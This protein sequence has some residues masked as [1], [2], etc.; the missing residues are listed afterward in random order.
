MKGGRLYMLLLGGFLAFVFLSELKAPRKFTWQPTYDSRDKEPFGCYVFDDVARSSFADYKVIKSTFYQLAADV[1]K[2]ADRKAYL[3]VEQ[4]MDVSETDRKSIFKL[5]DAGTDVMLCTDEPLKALF[6]TLQF[7]CS[8]VERRGLFQPIEAYMEAHSEERDSIYLGSSAADMPERRLFRVIPLFHKRYLKI[9]GENRRHKELKS[10]FSPRVLACDNHNRPLAVQFNIGNARLFILTT[11]LMFTNYGVLDGDNAA[12][13]FGLLSLLREKSIVRLEGY[14]VHNDKPATPLRYILQ[15]P[16]LLYALYTALATLILFMA[17]TAQRRQRVIPVVNAP[18]NRTLGF[19]K[20]I[21]NLYF[22][23][24]DNAEILKLKYRLFSAELKRRTTLDITDRAPDEADFALLSQLTGVDADVIRPLLK[25]IL[26]GTYRS[27]V[28]D[29]MLRR[30][31]D[32]MNELLR[33][34]ER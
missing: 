24:H 27:Y 17:F 13:A 33:N 1:A 23:Q 16:S 3:V 25:N 19:M 20:L 32:G 15:T 9:E 6:D 10:P 2:T 29:E 28:T 22:Q 4:R 11:P 30:Y 21:S 14:G 31:I 26:M 34:S 12:Y 18:P 8:I 7:D 5:L